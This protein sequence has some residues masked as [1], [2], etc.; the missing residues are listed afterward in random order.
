[1]D[2]LNAFP[3]HLQFCLSLHFLFVLSLE[4]SLRWKLRVFSGVFWAFVLPWAC[5]LLSKSP[6]I[7]GCFWMPFSPQLLLPTFGMSIVVKINK[8]KPPLEWNQEVEGEALTPYHSLS[9][10]DPTGRDVPC[11]RRKKGFLLLVAAQPTR[12][13]HHSTNETSLHS[14]LPV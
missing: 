5:T 7:Y 12:D 2:S 6:I 11:S 13:W 14:Q 10:A 9:I 1:M 4:I 8:W 3:G